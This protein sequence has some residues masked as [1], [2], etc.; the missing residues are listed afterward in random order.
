M[1]N[2]FT[3]MKKKFIYVGR[4]RFALTYT[5]HKLREEGVTPNINNL[6]DKQIVRL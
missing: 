6:S 1:H 3:A 5:P 2:V 4:E